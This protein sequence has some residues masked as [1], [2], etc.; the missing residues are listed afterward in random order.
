[1]AYG[2]M[3]MFSLAAATI[4]S[5]ASVIS[6]T[7]TY[8]CPLVP[9]S[10]HNKVD[11][12]KTKPLFFYQQPQKELSIATKSCSSPIVEIPQPQ[13]SLYYQLLVYFY[14]IRIKIIDY[15]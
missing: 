9:K 3:I 8:Y 11:T 4:I 7:A 2:N 6:G 14:S 1:M 10:V 13:I 5:M 15:N 12:L